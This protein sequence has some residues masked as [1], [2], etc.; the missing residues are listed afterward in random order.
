[1]RHASLI[2][3]AILCVS[4]PAAAQQGRERSPEDYDIE[5]GGSYV[6]LYEEGGYAST[7][8]VLVEGGYGI[9]TFRRWRVEAITEVMF[10]HFDDLDATYKQFAAGARV[11]TMLSPRIRAFGQFQLGV[12]N[13]G[14]AKSAT[15]M[16]IMPGAGLNY[17]VLTWLD[18]RAMVDFPFVRYEAGT[19]SQVRTSIGITV[20]LG[21]Q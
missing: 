2:L 13:D 18:A 4:V 12:Q 21:G 6:F 19:F 15:G 14:L 9:W 20:P 16:V 8:G 17:A 10:T 11:A 7:A 1:M 3:A 5:L